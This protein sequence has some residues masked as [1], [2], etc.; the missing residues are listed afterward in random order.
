[1]GELE[2]AAILCT[3]L[4]GSEAETRK[5]F[6]TYEMTRHIRVDCE[7]DSHVIE[8]AL[9]GTSS[10]RD[11]VH[12]ALFAAHLT[13]KE[14]TVIMIDRDGYVGRFEYEM[15]PVTRAAGVTYI[16]CAKDVIL[17]WAAT[18][19]LRDIPRDPTADD[20]VLVLTILHWHQ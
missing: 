1:M 15:R 7:T 5:Y 4:G 17:R 20:I 10:A 12:Q 14:P 13:G 3:F 8:V 9:D 11:S 6:D 18:S 19:G 16:R 2:L